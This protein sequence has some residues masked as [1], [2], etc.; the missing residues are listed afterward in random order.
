MPHLRR[1]GVAFPIAAILIALVSA[2]D[3]VAESAYSQTKLEAYVA[4]WTRVDRLRGRW[5]QRFGQTDNREQNAALEKEV[6]AEI[7]ATPGMTVVEY[8]EIADAAR[9]DPALMERISSIAK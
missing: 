3:L 4:A 1:G 8:Q 9:N 7:N 5:Q 2:A 6:N